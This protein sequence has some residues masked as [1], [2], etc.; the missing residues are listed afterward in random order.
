MLH[1]IPEYLVR[2]DREGCCNKLRFLG[3]Q[4]GGL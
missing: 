3:E 2:T 1:K 4:K